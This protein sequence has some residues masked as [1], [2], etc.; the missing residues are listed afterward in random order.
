MENQ[1]NSKNIILNYG[2]YLGISS[3]FVGLIKYAMGSLYTTEFYSAG[4]GLILLIAF[5]ILGIKKFKSDNGGFMNFGQGVKI[6]IGVTLIATIITILYYVLLSTVIEPD[7]MTNTIEA[8]KVMFADS[9]GMTEG[10]IEE[11]TKNSEDNFY[12]SLFG[13]IVIWNLFLGGVISLI[14]AA[15]MKKSEEDTY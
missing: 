1:A 4:A 11:A 9:F 6:G 12:L 5:V 7:F 8:Q 2:L 15:I 13:G 3:V 10:Q 14:A